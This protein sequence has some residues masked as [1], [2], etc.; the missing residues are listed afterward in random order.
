MKKIL[1]IET[2]PNTP[3][4]ETSIEIALSLK[5]KNN[6][7]FF[8]WCGYDL[9]WK[10]WEL[11]L[12]K[13]S[14]LFSYE[15]KIIEIENF[16]KKKNIIV[17][18]KIDLDYKI[19]NY[20][21]KEINNFKISCNLEKYI[22]KKK[23]YAGKSCLSS[24]ISKYHTSDLSVF[25]KEIP[26]ALESGC[27]IFERTNQIIKRINPETVVTFNSRF[28]LSRPIIDSA[29]NL[30]KNILI[31]ERGS[32]PKRYMVYN[33]D[34][35]DKYS[36]FK[37]IQ[38]HWKYYK[39]KNN[40]QK[41]TIGK[42]YYNLIYRRKFFKL[43]GLNFER[44]SKNKIINSNNQNII[45]FFCS[46]DHEYNSLALEK[47]NN[48]YIS[49]KWKSQ[50]K[51]IMSVINI[52]KN[53]KNFTLYIKAHPNFSK[54]NSID[55]K[56]KKI[57]F[58]N[59]K[60]LPNNFS[61]DTID[62]IKKSN[63]VITYGSTLELISLYLKKNT[64]SMFKNMYSDFNILNYPKDEKSLKKM[65][66]N[67]KN[68]KQRKI[69]QLYKIGFFLMTYGIKYKFFKPIGFYDGS[70]KEKKINHYGPLINFL[71]KIKFFKNT[72]YE[73]K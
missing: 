33:Y 29:K 5:K 62:L 23:F 3:H 63:V 32:T 50:F 70:I 51:A 2:F 56:L 38:S 25:K 71:I 42:K 58:K 24:L 44:Q 72:K 43:L 47:K 46:T 9:P 8:Y 57:K 60:Y 17:I 54:K 61:I 19:K 67:K 30:K 37:L 15:N 55:N 69:L 21:E 68:L 73:D 31:H 49:P 64:I 66:Y 27:I 11:P 48:F 13:K 53:K 41:K 14:L 40:S 35:F 18:K 52:I 34:I 28:I 6:K 12:F 39:N 45:S 1:I 7:V 4:I 20:I 65:I 59:I 36:F 16:L 26:K 10:D 22:Y